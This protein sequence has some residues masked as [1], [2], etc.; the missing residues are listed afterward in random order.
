MNRFAD[1]IRHHLDTFLLDHAATSVRNLLGAR[2]GHHAADLVAAGLDSFFLNHTADLVGAS[3]GFGNHLADLIA[4]GLNAFFRDHAADLVGASP[5]FGYHLADFVAAGLNSF[6]L[7]HTAYLV[8]ASL[9]FGYHLA[10]FVAAG[11]NAFFLNHAAD[12]VA[13]GLGSG[14]ADVF[15]AVDGLLP[16]FRYPN[17]FTNLD[18]WALGLDHFTTARFIAA[19][20][21]AWIPDP[22]SGRL[23][24]LANDRSWSAR[25]AGFPMATAD[26][27]AFGVV[28]RFANRVTDVPG[29]GFPDRLADGVTD[30]L[31]PGFPDRLTDG[32][33]AGLGFPDRLADGVTDV[34]G[35]GFPDRLA[36][37]VA[38]STVFRLVDRFANRIAAFAI[39]CFRDVL[40]TI[41]GLGFPN[42]FVACFVA[43]VLLFFVDD[44]FAGFHY[45]MALLFAASV[46]DGAATWPT[47]T[48]SGCPTVKCLSIRC[49]ED[50]QQSCHTRD[51]HDSNHCL[52]PSP[53]N[54]RSDCEI[55]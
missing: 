43:G 40:H 16:D 30:V 15:H 19:S 24:T 27:D 31:G 34:L 38:T 8:G 39:S 1:R 14:F 33:A 51:C 50:G 32:V 3:P 26:I 13:A 11:L 2:L 29:L 36:D 21:A 23:H 28:D 41:D 7:N 47:T 6:F 18:W 53:A 22:C 4:A 37:G 9:G 52:P 12:F 45:R 48:Q 5:G 46:V 54:I 20:A 55:F 44:L 35:L 10:D 42:R 49:R 17:L 25:H